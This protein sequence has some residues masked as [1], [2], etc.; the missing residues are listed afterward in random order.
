MARKIA[1]VIL[2]ILAIGIFLVVKRT[3]PWPVT[4]K[5]P[6]PEKYNP[7]PISLEAVF[8]NN[9]SW[10]ATLSA[11]H[12]TTIIATG[13]VIPARAANYQAVVRYKDILWPW[14]KTA[15]IL[16]R[17]DITLINLESPLFP[18]CKAE[19]STTM[20]FCG[21][22][23]NLEGLEFAGVDV[24]S[25]ANNHMGN[26]GTAG[27]SQTKK[28]L[29]EAGILVTGVSGPVYKTVKNIRFA[30]L[31]YNTIGAPE[32]MISW[33]DPEKMTREISQARKN[34]DVV[35]VE[36][37][38][39]TEYT[40]QPNDQ[41]RELAHQAIDDGADLIV[42]NH[43]HWIQSVEIYKGKFVAYAHGNFI[44]DQE[45]SEKTKEGVVGKYTFFDNK[46]VDAE[47]LPVK[48]IDYGQP[49]FLEGTDKE[50][51]LEEM[52]TSSIKLS[53]LAQ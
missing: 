11:E 28:L 10:T 7:V 48:I 3:P 2:V 17:A 8:V 40:S 46:L 31:G 27:I 19:F 43:P 21:S 37:H 33:A 44:F 36:F 42:G 5:L 29:E 16:R 30:F 51:I 20:I 6:P 25:L 13:D 1:A 35:V 15:A 23:Q 24:A 14:Q 9:H 18:D 50:K 39:G 49:Y 32:K 47:F 53:G 34:A 22:S 4:L 26:Y 41:Q 45:W 38:W 12:V 52:K